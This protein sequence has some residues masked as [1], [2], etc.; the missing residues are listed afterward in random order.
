MSGVD[1]H[2]Y[3]AKWFLLQPIGSVLAA[4][5]CRDLPELKLLLVSGRGNGGG[6]GEEEEEE[7]EEDPK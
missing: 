4:G 7:E 5:G 1:V 3:L 2:P 6:G